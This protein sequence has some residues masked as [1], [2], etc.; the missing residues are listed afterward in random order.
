MWGGGLAQR[1]FVNAGMRFP[2]RLSSSAK[3]KGNSE[4]GV[5]WGKGMPEV[6][7][8]KRHH[9]LWEWQVPG[10]MGWGTPGGWGV[11]PPPVWGGLL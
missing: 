5:F 7:I 6:G 8:V 11:A 9:P 3:G 1:T 2:G 4:E 10:S